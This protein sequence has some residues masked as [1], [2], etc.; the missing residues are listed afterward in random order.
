LNE[1]VATDA[2]KISSPHVFTNAR[3]LRSA[4]NRKAHGLKRNV[5][6][7]DPIERVRLLS[8]PA[9]EKKTASNDLLLAIE[10]FQERYK[11]IAL[12]QDARWI[13]AE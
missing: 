12:E 5:A 13:I 9:R 7:A 4:Q 6:T 1:S 2:P 8:V 3:G 10:M 11:L